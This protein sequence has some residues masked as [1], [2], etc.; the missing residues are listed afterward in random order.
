MIKC[1]LHVITAIYQFNILSFIIR[2]WLA[3]PVATVCSDRLLLGCPISTL[4]LRENP[5]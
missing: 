5:S 3:F 1:F 2:H 4:V